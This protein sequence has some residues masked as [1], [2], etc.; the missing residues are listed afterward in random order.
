MHTAMQAS[1]QSR[2]RS[3]VFWN[4][5]PSCK[6]LPWLHCSVNLLPSTSP[7][8]VYVV[9]TYYLLFI[10][11]CLNPLQSSFHHCHYMKLFLFPTSLSINDPAN[12]PVYSIW[13]FEV[14]F[15]SFLSFISLIPLLIYHQI[16]WSFFHTIC[17][18]LPFSQLLLFQVVTS[19][20]DYSN[21]I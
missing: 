3:H 13:G 4:P 6:N 1:P 8:L 9:Y 18:I 20:L 12:V 19:Y 2:H 5:T 10:L 7:N 14:T 15:D 17:H 16:F 21:S 11:S